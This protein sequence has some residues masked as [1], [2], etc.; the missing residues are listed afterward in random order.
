MTTT[1]TE[2]CT[3]CQELTINGVRCHETGCP[4]WWKGMKRECKWCGEVF[5]L[6]GPAH[7]YC[8][9]DCHYS[10]SN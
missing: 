4:D 8:S 7:V 2:R 9:Q 1:S 5:P 3:S 10:D 6:Q